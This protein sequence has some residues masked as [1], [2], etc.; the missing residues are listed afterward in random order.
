MCSRADKGGMSPR[1]SGCQRAI[2]VYCAAAAALIGLLV[3]M[4]WAL[5]I[6]VLQR[7]DPSLPPMVPNTA[8]MAAI[9][10]ATICLH[11]AG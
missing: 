9:L 1:P 7:V 6:D 5:D 10:G 2:A 8:V 4:G 11:A 3:L